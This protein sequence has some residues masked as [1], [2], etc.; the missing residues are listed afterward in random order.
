LNHYLNAHPDSP[1]HIQPLK[2]ICVHPWQG[3]IS[4]WG[5]AGLTDTQRELQGNDEE[6]EARKLRVLRYPISKECREEMVNCGLIRKDGDSLKV[7]H[8]VNVRLGGD[9]TLT[10]VNFDC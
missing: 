2:I 3:Q 6:R 1:R 4:D 10:V 9:G 8:S 5:L 7:P